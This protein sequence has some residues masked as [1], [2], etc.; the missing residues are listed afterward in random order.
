MALAWAASPRSLIRYTV[1]GIVSAT[2]PPI[3]VFLGASLVNRIADA[4]VNALQFSDMLPILIGLWIAAGVQRAVGAYM[5][6]G[7]NLFVRRVQLEAERR[8]LT[9]ASKLD[10]GHFDN[11]DWHDRLARAKRDVSWRPGDLTWSVLGLSG[12]VVTI[13][14]MASLLA[15]LHYVLVLLALAAAV[16]SLAL[17]R[18]VT[19]RLYEFFYKETPEEREREYLGDLL[20]QPRSTKEIRAYVLADYLLGRHRNLSEDLFKQR[21]Q[22]YRSGTRTSM[23]TG[24]VSGTTLALAYV[25]VAVRGAEGSIDPGGVVLVI[26]AFT[27]VAGTL[28]QISSTFVAVDQ[29]TTFLD[30]YF[31]FLAIEPLVPAPADPRAIP[32]GPI[33]GIDFD[34]VTFSYPGG[35]E[36]AIVGLRL[37]IRSGE[38]IALVGENGAG[39]STLVKLLLRFYDVDRGSIRVGGVDLKHVDPEALR[40]RIGV[41]FQDY[42]NYE[43][44]IRENVVIGRPNGPK[45]DERVLEALR[46]SRSEWLV[47]KMPKGLDSRVGRMFEGGHDLSGG[48]WQRLALARIMY[49]DADIWILDEPTSSLDPEAE[50][51]IFAELKENLRG[52]IGIVISHRFSTVR[53]ADRIAVIADG[54]V[55]ELGTHD[56]LLRADGRYAQLF[57]LQAAGYR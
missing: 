13:V 50:A 23:L 8:L 47:K 32:S 6:Y 29:H 31:S 36:P 11:S 22:M 56:E 33:D 44:T 26:G 34:D 40:S 25:F 17:E 53:I 18:R 3:A 20:V 51:G 19:S 4:R 16:L 41:L 38:L 43:L 52:R 14:L 48:E 28:G 42:A 57:E 24:L 10:I 35:T 46:R 55:T 7:R 21:E 45:D 49:R 1:L 30:D 9:Q 27:S 12:N 39:K 2:M 54:R 37:H 15:S 5:G